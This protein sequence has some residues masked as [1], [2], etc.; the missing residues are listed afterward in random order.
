LSVAPPTQQL[1]QQS[2]TQDIA[3][4]LYE[5]EPGALQQQYPN[6]VAP[7]EHMRELKFECQP[8]GAKAGSQLMF[9]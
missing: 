7:E 4:W 3:F 1:Y 8:K 6:G 5:T 2:L 9:V